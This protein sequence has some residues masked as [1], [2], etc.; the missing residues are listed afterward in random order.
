MPRFECLLRPHL[1][2]GEI[3]IFIASETYPVSGTY[4]STIYCIL[5]QT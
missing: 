3:R 4:S 5:T 1:L 2:E